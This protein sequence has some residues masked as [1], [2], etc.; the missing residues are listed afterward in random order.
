MLSD[1]LQTFSNQNSQPDTQISCHDVHQSKS[2][3]D[4]EFVDPQL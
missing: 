1:L 3:D 2:R 4:F